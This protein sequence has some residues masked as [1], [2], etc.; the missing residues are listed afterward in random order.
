MPTYEYRCLDCR[1][2]F[3]VFMTYAEYG[4]REVACPHC[5]STRI[6]R[7][8]GRIRIARSEDALLDDLA[9]PAALEGLEDDPKALGRMMR[10]MSRELGEDICPEFD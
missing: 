8:I 3:E 9:D 6:Q 4:S 7:R 2:R 5:Q 10:R 1:R